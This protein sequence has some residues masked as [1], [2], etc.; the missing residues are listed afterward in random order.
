MAPNPQSTPPAQ[1]GQTSAT[2]GSMS[3]TQNQQ[4]TQHDPAQ[5]QQL[6]PTGGPPPVPHT[7]E[8]PRPPPQQGD[9]GWIPVNAIHVPEH[10]EV[11]SGYTDFATYA[12]A[13]VT[14]GC[15]VYRRLRVSA[16]DAL[17]V[18][19]FGIR[20]ERKNDSEYRWACAYIRLTEDI[21]FKKGYMQSVH[22]HVASALCAA[23]DL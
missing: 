18:T 20:D 13:D 4:Q 7:A 5:L 23:A 19:R 6:D 11:R 2:A 22:S 1:E 21:E 14:Q 3:A 10:I 15:H 17:I 9:H 12:T 8:S 16:G